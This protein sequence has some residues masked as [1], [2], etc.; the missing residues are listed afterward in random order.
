MNFF[1]SFLISKRRFDS[2]KLDCSAVICPVI[3]SG[4]YRCGFL[5]RSRLS[6]FPKR[7]NK[8][9]VDLFSIDQKY[10]RSQGSHFHTGYFLSKTIDVKDK[11][12][13]LQ[14]GDWNKIANKFENIL[15]KLQ[16]STFKNWLV[17]RS[18]LYLNSARLNPKCSTSIENGFC[19]SLIMNH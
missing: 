1:F 17:L 13:A 9:S 8:K 5:L 6:S 7:T 14:Y 16:R 19:Y 15:S 10:P 12:R 4:R 18:S 3:L 11:P 2:E